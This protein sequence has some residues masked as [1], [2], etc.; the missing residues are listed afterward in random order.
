MPQLLTYSK[1]NN[2]DPKAADGQGFQTA[3]R[4]CAIGLKIEL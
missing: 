2:G 3:S 4:W 1:H